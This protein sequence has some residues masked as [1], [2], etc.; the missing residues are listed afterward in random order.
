MEVKPGVFDVLVIKCL[1]QLSKG[2][3]YASLVL[4]LVYQI[5]PVLVTVSCLGL[6]HVLG[7]SLK[8]LIK[9]LFNYYWRS[10]SHRWFHRPNHGNRSPDLNMTNQV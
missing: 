3:T 8:R 5:N 1:V 10:P 6:S 7:S 2:V 4:L 9:V